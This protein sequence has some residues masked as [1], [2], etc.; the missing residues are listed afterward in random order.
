MR[1]IYI[2]APNTQLTAAVID[3]AAAADCSE[4]SQGI[5]PRLSRDGVTGEYPF[6]YTEPD[7]PEVAPLRAAVTVLRNQFGTTRTNLTQVSNALDAITL[8]LRRIAKN[9]MDR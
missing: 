1:K 7:D 3:A 2:V 9:E 4:I 6:A 5:P 8:I